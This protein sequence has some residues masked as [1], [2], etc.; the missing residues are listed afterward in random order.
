MANCSSWLFVY[1]RVRATQDKRPSSLSAMPNKQQTPSPADPQPQPPV[2]PDLPPE[3]IPPVQVFYCEVCTFPL[4][5]CEFGSSFTRCKEWLR[6]E[7]SDLFDKYYSDGVDLS[8][9]MI[10]D[11]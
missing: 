5:Y 6:D 10:E 2:Q 4:E 3:P 7:H 9:L 1:G 11:V 8:C